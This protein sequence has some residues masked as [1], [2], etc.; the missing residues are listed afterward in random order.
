MERIIYTLDADSE[1]RNFL[2]CCGESRM[3][4]V[5]DGNTCR[6]SLPLLPSLGGCTVIEVPAGERCKETGV[7]QQIWKELAEAGARRNDILINVGG[8][9]VSD[10]GGFAAATYMRGIRHVNIPTTLLACVDASSGGKTGIDFMG[11]KNIVGAFHAP[12]LTV[13]S[14]QFLS[15]LP[16]GEMLSGFAEMIKHAVLDSPEH[17]EALL[18]T[19]FF[20]LDS[21][22]TLGLI[23]RS[24]EVKRCVVEADPFEKGERRKLNLGHTAGHALESLCIRRGDPITH[25]HAVALGMLAELSLAEEFP[26]AL[27]SRLRLAIRSLY[28]PVDLTDRDAESLKEYMLRDKKNL[29]DGGVAFIRMRDVGEADLFATVVP[30]RLAEALI[31]EC[32]FGKS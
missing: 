6:K 7:L 23:T 16:H 13:V 22:H 12:V 8:G 29:H 3:F 26:R 31:G 14:P 1:V 2:R 18:S 15:T 21:A 27:F 30:E 19:D 25:G 4:V 9:S 24:A 28:A 17:L 5:S 20:A 10:L 32:C 11:F